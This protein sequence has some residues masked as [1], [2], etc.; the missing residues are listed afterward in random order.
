MRDEDDEGVWTPINI[1]SIKISRQLNVIDV[2]STLIEK[3]MD[4]LKMYKCV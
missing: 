4:Y 2:A 3:S 1:V